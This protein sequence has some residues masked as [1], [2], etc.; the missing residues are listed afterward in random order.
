MNTRFVKESEQDE[1][2]E[3][4]VKEPWEILYDLVFNQPD[5]IW[6]KVE[7]LVSPRPIGIL[8]IIKLFLRSIFRFE[9]DRNELRMKDLI[10]YGGELLTRCDP[11][12]LP[13]ASRGDAFKYMPGPRMREMFPVLLEMQLK[14]VESLIVSNSMERYYSINLEGMG[15]CN[16]AWGVV[17]DLLYRYKHLPINVEL[18]EDQPLSQDVFDILAEI[19]QETGIKIYIDDLCACFHELPSSEEYM[20]ILIEKLHPYISAVKIDY[21]K[22][23]EIMTIEGRDCVEKHLKDF[24]WLWR[25]HCRKKELPV[26]IF[27]S[28]PIRN[29]LWLRSLEEIAKE[30]QGCKYQIGE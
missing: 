23:T 22:M 12:I 8:D 28:M 11:K 5:K 9:R 26:V 1:C 10:R 27:E 14:F 20:S 19:C 3:I 30:Y 13:P 25:T 16:K 21:D 4:S 24:A 7:E 2:A 17:R 18:K 29:R 6:F 15:S